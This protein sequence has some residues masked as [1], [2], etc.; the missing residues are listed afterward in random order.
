MLTT[1]IGNKY[2]LQIQFIS[3]YVGD[4]LKT[5]KMSKMWSLPL[6]RHICYVGGGKSVYSLRQCFLMLAAIKMGGPVEENFE[7]PDA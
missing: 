2:T 3:C 1:V 4:T 7:I 5:A 6:R